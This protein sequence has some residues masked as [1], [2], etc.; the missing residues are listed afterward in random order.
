MQVGSFLVHVQY[1]RDKV[2]F[3]ECRFQ[4]MQICVCPIIQFSHPFYLHHLLMGSCQNNTEDFRLVAS[5]LA[6]QTSIVYAMLNGIGTCMNALRKSDKF[7]V[8][9]CTLSIGIVR[10]IYFTIG[11]LSLDVC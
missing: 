2:L 6:V 3:S 1:A 9:M 7:S 5:D 4:P 10:S 11:S 8:L